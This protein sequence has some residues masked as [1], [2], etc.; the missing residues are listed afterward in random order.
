MTHHTQKLGVSYHRLE[1]DTNVVPLDLLRAF[2][3]DNTDLADNPVRWSQITVI[4]L[5]IDNELQETPRDSV[6]RIDFGGEYMANCLPRELPQLAYLMFVH[7]DAFAIYILGLIERETVQ[8]RLNANL[9]LTLG[10]INRFEWERHSYYDFPLKH[11]YYEDPTRMHYDLDQ[12]TE[13]VDV[14][15]GRMAKIRPI[16]LGLP[17]SL[18]KMRMG[19][20]LATILASADEE[21][22]RLFVQRELEMLWNR[23]RQLVDHIDRASFTRGWFPGLLDIVVPPEPRL[24]LLGE[25][26][27]HSVYAKVL[28]FYRAHYKTGDPSVLYEGPVEFLT[29]VGLL[30]CVLCSR[31]DCPRLPIVDGRVVFGHMELSQYLTNYFRKTTH[32][33]MHWANSV[34]GT[35]YAQQFWFCDGDPYTTLRQDYKRV[36]TPHDRNDR[37]L[38]S[39]VGTTRRAFDVLDRDEQQ[40]MMKYAKPWIADLKESMTELMPKS[41]DRP[42]G[43]INLEYEVVQDVM[44]KSREELLRYAESFWPPCL[45]NYAKSCQGAKHLKHHDRR[46]VSALLKVFNYPLADAQQLFYLM[47]SETIAEGHMSLDGFLGGKRGSIIGNDYASSKSVNL[48]VSCRTQI[49]VGRCPF[50]DST[51]IEDIGRTKCTQHM[52]QLREVEGKQRRDLYPIASP[53]SYFAQRRK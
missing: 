35:T 37:S 39:L 46:R 15:F 6:L 27:E 31:Y 25:V 8:A 29:E 53:R 33:A 10:D 48:G 42:N 21:V 19:F 9:Y 45:V 2:V 38:H 1:C 4:Y 5:Q 41:H 28:R 44:P 43:H 34:T 30:E 51:D 32:R 26:E 20:F 17:K 7:T 14:F 11:G 36:G 40:L 18:N 22:G 24:A 12:K 3:L 47:F 49:G 13:Y 50:A 16:E 23:L 52:N